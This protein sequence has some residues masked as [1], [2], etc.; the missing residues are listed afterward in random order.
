MET[1]TDHPPPTSPPPPNPS[2]PPPNTF[3][4]KQ[5]LQDC[6]LYGGDHRRFYPIDGV[7]EQPPTQQPNEIPTLRPA[8]RPAATTVNHGVFAVYNGYAGEEKQ[9]MTE[10][11]CQGTF[12][13]NKYP[14]H[15]AAY[16]DDLRTL[17][18]LLKTK[19]ADGIVTDNLK[20]RTAL[21]VACC[22]GHQEVAEALLKIGGAHVQ[23]V[24]HWG[25]SPLMYAV[26]S[27][28]ERLVRWL[29]S[30]KGAHLGIQG[31]RGETAWLLSQVEHRGFVQQRYA[32]TDFIRQTEDD[33]TVQSAANGWP[34]TFGATVH[35]TRTKKAYKKVTATFSLDGTRLYLH[36]RCGTFGLKWATRTFNI[37][38]IGVSALCFGGGLVLCACCCCLLVVVLGKRLV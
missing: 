32:L 18:R 28:H 12:G 9:V 37:T 38:R 10:R 5:K 8:H 21:H 19:Q 11:M 6:K 30:H 29:I 2:S 26:Y 27:G 31:N 34:C 36:Y 23:A 24:D 20:G 7:L 22:F 35:P 16:K 15:Y 33:L 1:K 4:A 13:G 25:W 17:K 14:L 3:V